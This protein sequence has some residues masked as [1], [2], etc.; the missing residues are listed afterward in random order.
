MPTIRVVVC[1]PSPPMSELMMEPIPGKKMFTM[2][3]IIPQ[4][5]S[6]AL[7]SAISPSSILK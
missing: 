4:G 1:T 5:L 2:K 7:I 6:T 3:R